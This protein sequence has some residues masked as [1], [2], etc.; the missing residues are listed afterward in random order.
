MIVTLKNAEECGSG[1]AV[2]FLCPES[3]MDIHAW[4]SSGFSTYIR[5]LAVG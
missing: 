3:W 2:L 4:L 5:Y 1:V